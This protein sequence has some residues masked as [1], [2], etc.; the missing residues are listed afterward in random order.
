VERQ[1]DFGVVGLRRKISSGRRKKE[2]GASK[3]GGTDEDGVSPNSSE[4]SEARVK[5]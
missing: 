1:G 2:T 4:K 3:Q 5:N